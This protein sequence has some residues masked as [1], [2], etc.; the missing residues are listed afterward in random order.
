MKKGWKLVLI[1]VLLIF[2][3]GGGTYGYIH[4]RLTSTASTVEHYLI[5]EKGIKKTDIEEIEANLVNL[6]GDR[7]YLVYVKLKNDDRKYYYYKD[8]KKNKIVL[9]T[10]IIN[11]V[12]YEPEELNK[13]RN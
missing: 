12:E 11:G 7:K 1:I 13:K 3:I 5:K 8:T 4:Y 10:F 6:T 9:E 2:A